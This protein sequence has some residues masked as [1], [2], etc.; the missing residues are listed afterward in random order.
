MENKYIN[1]YVGI[2]LLI[3]GFIMLTFG[4]LFIFSGKPEYGMYS[5][6]PSVI[7]L[8]IGGANIRNFII[9]KNSDY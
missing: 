7:F 8:S 5:A 9:N 1:Y 3:I 4:L 2:I 6:A